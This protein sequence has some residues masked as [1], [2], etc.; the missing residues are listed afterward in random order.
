MSVM[1]RCIEKYQNIPYVVL[2]IPKIVPDDNFQSLWQNHAIPVVRIKPDSRYHYTPEEAQEKY[3]TTGLTNQY[4]MP[5]WVGFTAY[6]SS[7]V[8]V[9]KRWAESTIDGEFLL[10]KFMSQLYEYLPVKKIKT[11]YFWSNQQAIELHKDLEPALNIPTSI[12]ISISD[13]N[14]TPTFYLQPLPAGKK[15]GGEE[16]IKFDQSLAKFVNTKNTTS[17]TFIYNNSSWVHGAFK[18]PKYSKILCVVAVSVWDWGKYYELIGKSIQ[19][20]GSNL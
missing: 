12:R 15:G 2:D 13:D 18:D 16:K 9:N 4:T 8:Y 1:N 10:P 7:P 3:E 20:Y 5:L 19:R 14:P 11:V 17:N 6:K